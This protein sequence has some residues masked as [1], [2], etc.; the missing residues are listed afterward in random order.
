MNKIIF[1]LLFLFLQYNNLFRNSN[2]HRLTVTEFESG[3]VGHVYSDE[4]LSFFSRLSATPPDS[5][6]IAIDSVFWILKGDDT[7]DVIVEMWFFA[8]ENSTDALLGWK[9]TG[10]DAT[11]IGT[12]RFVKHQGFDR[13]GGSNYINTNFNPST[14]GAGI[15]T[16]NAQSCG[17]YVRTNYSENTIAAGCRIA[18]GDRM[19]Q[20]QPR[21]TGLTISGSICQNTNSSYGS[22]STSVGLTSLN[23]SAASGATSTEAFRNGVSNAH[24]DITSSSIPSLNFY[25]LCV[26]NNGTGAGAGTFQIAFCF[27]GGNLSDS[28]HLTLFNA[29]EQ[30]MDKLKTGVVS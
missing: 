12:P 20:I 26:N 28:Q 19:I 16:Q 1:F 24:A 22:V 3:E 8:A 23:R 18:N 4:S 13:N 5:V 17:I 15:L 2:Y 10:N 29:V 25:V 11:F 6:K 30:Y 7:Y 27:V 21:V 14:D 9:N